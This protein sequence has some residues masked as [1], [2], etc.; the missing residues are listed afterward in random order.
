MIAVSILV[1]AV[2]IFSHSFYDLLDRTL[3]ESD[4]L[5]I[6]R[7]MSPFVCEFTDL[8]EIR[9]RRAGS[10][11][12]IDIVAEFDA[13]RRVG[14]VQDTAESCGETSEIHPQ[15]PR[16][17]RLWRAERAGR[18]GGREFVIFRDGWHGHAVRVTMSSR[19]GWNSLVTH[20]TLLCLAG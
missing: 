19:V 17:H 2:G 1:P 9:S 18:A 16:H 10:V 7:E 8:H 20:K 6:L 5:I 3:E 15:E 13:D 14:E 11:V 12:F 4:K